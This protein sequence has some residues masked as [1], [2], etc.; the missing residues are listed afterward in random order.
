MK[1]ININDYTY[2]LPQAK[3]AADPLKHRDDSKL[4]VYQKGGITHTGFK[5]LIDF[6]PT[7]AFLFFN[8]TKVIPARIHFQK[9]TGAEIEI[10]LLSP[11]KPSSLRADV[12]LST[13]QCTWQCTVGNLKRWKDGQTLSTDIKG[14]FL[15]AKLINRN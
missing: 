12:M 11:V 9:E 1:V 5:S 3:I 14:T 6:L 7:N 13:D 4:L 10:F 8:D 15:T 2:N